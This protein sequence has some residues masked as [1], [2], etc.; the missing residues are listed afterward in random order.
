MQ[1]I[2]FLGLP[3]SG[4]TTITKELI[5]ELKLLGLHTHDYDKIRDLKVFSD[6]KIR[7]VPKLFKFVIFFVRNLYTYQNLVKQS[8]NASVIISQRH[9]RS[10]VYLKTLFILDQLDNDSIVILEEGLLQNIWSLYLNSSLVDLTGVL[11]LV[12]SNLDKY[13]KY[14]FVFL[15]T[16]ISIAAS[17]IQ[18]RK[19]TFRQT[20]FN[21]MKD[22]VLKNTLKANENLMY[23]IKELFK[24]QYSFRSDLPPKENSKI[25]IAKLRTEEKL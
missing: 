16:D 1:I 13:D 3:G 23:R 19:K 6:F 15:E 10:L 12:H 4:K 21:R 5:E 22:D 25:I 11:E 18:G 7:T 17:R 14:T 9:K 20:R 2:E 24:V 8:K